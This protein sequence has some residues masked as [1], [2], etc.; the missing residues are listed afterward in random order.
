MIIVW[1]ANLLG[2]LESMIIARH[3]GHNRPLIRLRCVDQIYRETQRSQHHKP[4]FCNFTPNHQDT[5]NNV[6]L[7]Y[8]K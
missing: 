8:K 7:E 5:Q 6:K 3:I 2:S 1:V 4:H